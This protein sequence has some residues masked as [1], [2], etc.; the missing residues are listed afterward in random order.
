MLLP[1]AEAEVLK[2]HEKDKEVVD[3][4]RALQHIAGEEFECVLL[5]LGEENKGGEAESQQAEEDVQPRALRKRGPVGRR[6]STTRSTT[7]SSRTT[8]WKP[9][10]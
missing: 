2:Q 6:P 8:A 10:Q 3:R 5:P 1:D 9:I 7:S 4:E